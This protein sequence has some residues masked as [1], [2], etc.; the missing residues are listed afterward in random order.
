MLALGHIKTAVPQPYS[1]HVRALY[2][3]WAAP[4]LRHS[5]AE[6]FVPGCGCL[7]H[8]KFVVPKRVYLYLGSGKT[9]VPS[10][11]RHIKKAAPRPKNLLY[12]QH[13][14]TTSTTAL[15]YGRNTG[16][17]DRQ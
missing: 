8:H 7:R 17:I 2:R 16:P 14:K 15:I 11:L 13:I 12:L 4:A 5:R 9:A 6:T 1:V 3:L 10:S